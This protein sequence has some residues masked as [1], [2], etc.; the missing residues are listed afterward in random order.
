MMPLQCAGWSKEE[1]IQEFSGTLSSQRPF[2][3]F[4]CRCV[5]P[6]NISFPAQPYRLFLHIQITPV[7]FFTYHIH[8]PLHKKE[9][10]LFRARTGCKTDQ[11]ISV[12]VHFRFQSSF[13]GNAD[14]ILRQSAFITGAVRDP[15]DFFKILQRP[16]RFHTF[17][18][19]S[20]IFLP[21]F[22]NKEF[23]RFH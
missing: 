8:M 6:E 17:R 2:R 10:R 1:K 4:L 22:F 15:T 16:L 11:H 13:F 3:Y 21:P 7:F 20:H 19:I 12:P 9:R 18:K 23:L 5:R 14:N